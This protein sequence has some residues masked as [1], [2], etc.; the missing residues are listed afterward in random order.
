MSQ[1]AADFRGE[2][3]LVSCPGFGYDPKTAPTMACRRS[4]P[5]LAHLAR[6]I[7]MRI[8]P[9]SRAACTLSVVIVI[10]VASTIGAQQLSGQ[11]NSSDQT[12]AKLVADM[13]SKYHISQKHID[14]RIS[15]LLL[16]RLLKDLDP[17]KLYFL[18]SDIDVFSKY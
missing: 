9:P 3:H 13:I 10:L 15:Q 11:A 12:T 17:Q 5:V 4:F 16:K 1:C 8:S 7:F 2:P 6:M 18:Q 14:D